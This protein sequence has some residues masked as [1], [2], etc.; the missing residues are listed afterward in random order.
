MSACPMGDGTDKE[1][2]G[3]ALV[4]ERK[5]TRRERTAGEGRGGV[6]GN[7]GPRENGV[8]TPSQAARGRP[9]AWPSSPHA[10]TARQ[11]VSRGILIFIGRSGT[12]LD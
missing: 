7:R 12:P 2:G 10:W 3:A 9:G 5:E 8:P 4:R 6:T 1:R 11:L